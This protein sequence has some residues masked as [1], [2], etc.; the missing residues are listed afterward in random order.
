MLTQI[1]NAANI[2]FCHLG[3]FFPFDPPNNPK[4]QNFEKIAKAP[5]DIITLH[6]RTTNDDPMMYGF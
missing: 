4:N 5:G 3:P 2:I 1:W 6:L